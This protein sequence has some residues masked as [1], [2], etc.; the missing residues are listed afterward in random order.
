MTAT[1]WLVLAFVAVAVAAFCSGVLAS[2]GGTPPPP[3]EPR[4]QE[5]VAPRRWLFVT[6]RG[7]RA[8][9]WEI[10]A[11]TEPEALTLFLQRGGDPTRIMASHPLS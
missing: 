3:A 4:L 11:P 1:L 2:D 8:Q 6:G 5:P 9:R 7:P 10:D